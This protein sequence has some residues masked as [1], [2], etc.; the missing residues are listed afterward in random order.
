MPPIMHV[1]IIHVL[2]MHVRSRSAL[3]AIRPTTCSTWRM[4]FLCPS[5]CT[6]AD[7]CMHSPS[8]C[9]WHAHAGM[10]MGTGSAIAHRAVDSVMGPRTVEHVHTGAAAAAPMEAGAPSAAAP[11]G[12][13]ATQAKAFADCISRS[14]GDM[15]A[16]Q[17]RGW[18][19]MQGSWVEQ[20][21]GGCL[22]CR[23]AGHGVHEDVDARGRG[24]QHVGCRHQRNSCAQIQ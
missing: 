17:V 22:R 2:I 8:S 20:Q 6:N 19:G 16:C 10:A 1:P 14:G 21:Q 4:C 18:L 12:P 15:N 9:A 5:A 3:T 23:F 13:C 11:E 24:G 7:A